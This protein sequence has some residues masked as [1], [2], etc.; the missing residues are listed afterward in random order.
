MS[1]ETLRTALHE[2]RLLGADRPWTPPTPATEAEAERLL[3]L[4]ATEPAWPPGEIEVQPDG[5]IHLGWEAGERG[6]VT[7]SVD[8]H[9]LLTHS[10]VIDGDEYTLAEPWDGRSLT[11]WAAEVL[12]RLWA[13]PAQPGRTGDSPGAQPKAT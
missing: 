11:D 1:S 5:A 7:L 6:W 13:Q 8:G 12:R 10:A 2:A 4:L 9:A 3:A